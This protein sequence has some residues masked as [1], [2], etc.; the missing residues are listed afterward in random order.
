MRA[1]GLQ[2]RRGLRLLA[3]IVGVSGLALTVAVCIGIADASPAPTQSQTIEI[4]GLPGDAGVGGSYTLTVSGGGSGNPVLLSVESKSASVCELNGTTVTGT[5]IGECFIDATQA[6]GNGYAAAPDV[7][8]QFL[9]LFAG[10]SVSQS[11]ASSSFTLGATETDTV[12]VTGNAIAGAPQGSMNFYECGPGIATCDND[13]SDAKF[14]GSG[15]VSTASDD[16]STVVSSPVTP[17]QAGTYCFYALFNGEGDYTTNGDESSDACFTVNAPGSADTSE[18]ASFTSTGCFNWTVPDGV[19]SVQADAIGAAGATGTGAYVAA[20]GDGDAVSGAL[21]VSGGQVL[22]VCVDQGGAAGGGGYGGAGGG[23]AGVAIGASFTTQTAIVAGGGGGGAG[24]TYYQG[25]P[26]QGDPAGTGG[27]NATTADG[28]GSGTT[29]EAND[30]GGS[31]GGGGGGGYVGG[32]GGNASGSAPPTAEGGG[33]GTDYCD[34]TLVSNC[35]TAAKEGTGSSSVTLT[36]SL[37]QTISFNS[38]PPSQAYIGDSYNV[39]VSGGD[40]GNAVVLS[41]DPDSAPDACTVSSDEVSFTGLGLCQIDAKQAGGDGYAAAAEQDQQVSV[42]QAPSQISQSPASSSFALGA[43]DTDYV[44]VVGNPQTGAPTGN[45]D[46]WVCG[47]AASSCSPGASDLIT[48][49][50]ASLASE[51]ADSSLAIVPAFT[52]GS[53][54]TYCYAVAYSSTAYEYEQDTSADGCFAVNAPASTDTSE[55]ASFTSGGCYDWTVPDGVSSVQIDAIGAA[56]GLYGGSGDGVSGTAALS[57]G[58]AIDVCVDYGGGAPGN[59]GAKNSG[60]GASGVSAAS[61][62][63]D[64][65]IIAGGG[66]GGGQYSGAEGGNAGESAGGG[67]AAGEGQGGGG[68]SNSPIAGGGSGGSGT[69]GNGASG[70]AT[71]ASGPG[72]GGAGGAGGSEPD[73]DGGGGGGGAGYYGGGGGGGSVNDGDGGGAGG[74]GSDY[75]DTS[76]SGCAYASGAGIG[77]VAGSASGD[78]QVRLTYSLD[79]SFSFDGSPPTGATAG[80]SETISATP[81]ASGEPVTFQVSGQCSSS[82]TASSSVTLENTGKGSCEVDANEAG[83]NG[84]GAA[85][86][87]SES[88]DIAPA[89]A[90]VSQTPASSSFTLG[91]PENDNVTLTGDASLGAP[92]GQVDVWV[93]GPSLIAAGCDPGDLDAQEVSS[94]ALSGA[95]GDSSRAVALSFTPSATGTYCFYASYTS[96]DSYASSADDTTDGCFTVTAVAADATSETETFTA[97]GQCVNWNVPSDVS[98]L[99]ADAVGAAGLGGYAGYGDGVSGSFVASAKTALDVC[100]DYG[101]GGGGSR[102]TSGGGASGVARGGDFSA[103]VIVAGGGGSGG[104]AGGQG[105]SAGLPSGSDGAAGSPTG[106]GGGGGDNTLASGGAPGVGT[107]DG[108]SGSATNSDGPGVGGDGGGTSAWAGGGGGGGYYGGG[109]GAGSTIV[110]TGGGGGGGGSDYCAATCSVDSGAGTYPGAGAA[111]GHANVTLT[112]SLD[113]TIDFVGAPNAADVGDT[114]DAS[115]NVTSGGPVS[116]SIDSSTSGNC[117]IN[118]TTVTFTNTGTCQIDASQAGGDGYGPVST[119][120]IVDVQ[121][122]NLTGTVSA[123][124]SSF[125]LGASDTVTLTATGNAVAGAPG[126]S[127]TWYECGPSTGACDSGLNQVGSGTLSAVSSDSSQALSP[128]LTPTTA[129]TYCVGVTWSEG[130]NYQVGGITSDLACFTVNAPATGDTTES[131]QFTSAGCGDWTV[132]DGVTSV[133]ADAVGAAGAIGTIA[134]AAGGDGDGVSAT[135]AVSPGETLDVCVDQGGGTSDL[136]GSGGGAS[137][138]SLTTGFQSPALVAGGGGGGGGGEGAPGGNAGVAG[139]SAASGGGAG[140]ALGAGT[141]STDAGPGSGAPGAGTGGG[142]GGGGYVGGGGG[143]TSGLG[144]GGGA[145]GTDH[146][147][148]GGS[149][150]GCSTSEAAGTQTVAGSSSGDAQVTLTYSLDQAITFNSNASTPYVG[151]SYDVNATSDGGSGQPVELSIDASASTSGACSISG[152]EVQFTGIGTCQI[153]ANQAGGNGYGAAPQTDQVVQI[154]KAVSSTSSWPTSST[155]TLGAGETDNVSVTGQPS[156]G[157][158]SGSISFY[159]CGSSVT[160]CSSQADPVGSTKLTAAP[161]SDSSTAISPAFTPTGAGT[162]CFYAVYAGD[163]TNLGSSDSSSDECFTVDAAASGD[164]TEHAQFTTSGCSDWT[165][166]NDVSSVQADA[167]GAAGGGNGG[168]GDGVSATLSVSGG[169]TLDVCVDQGGASGGQGAS[170]GGGASGVASS[171]N[172]STPVLV[173]GGGGGGAADAAGLAAGSGA[174]G[175]SPSNSAGPGAGDPGRNGV[176]GGGGGGGGGYVGGYGGGG[177]GGGG[178]GGTDYCDTALA[179]S[180]STSAGAGTQTVAGSSS[181]DAQVTLTYSLDQVITFNSTASEPY[182]GESYDVNATSDGGSGQPVELSI[183]ATASTPDACTISGEEVQFTGLGTCQIDA[184]Q[185]GGKGYGAAPL[186]DQ[187]INVTDPPTSASSWPA[188]SAIALGGSDTDHLT[189]TGDAGLSAPAGSVS[190]YVC[191]PAASGCSSTADP[192][193]TAVALSAGTGVS[194]TAVSPA[195]TPTSSGTYCFYAVY[196]GA[197]NYRGSNDSTSDECF[198]VNA[199]TGATNTVAFTSAGCSDWTVPADVTSVSADAVGA[200]GQNGGGAGSTGGNGDEVAATLSVTPGSTLDVCVDQGAGAGG[201]GA[202]SGGGGGGASGVSLAADFSAPALVAGGGGGG[203]GNGDGRGGSGGAA[204]AAGGSGE[205]GGQAGA[206]GTSANYTPAGPGV[207]GAGGGGTSVGGGGGGGGGYSAGG[208]G[209]DS[210]QGTGGGGAGGTDYCVDSASVSACSSNAGAGTQAVAGS[211]PGDARV[212]LTYSMGQLLAFT[213]VAP[214]GATVGGSYLVSA[215]GGP[216]GSPVV[217]SIDASSTSGA[218]VVSGA[219]V[220]F[221]GA[222]NCVVDANQAGGAGYSAAPQANQSFTI[223]A[224]PATSSGTPP[225]TPSPTPQP[226]AV[227]HDATAFV[228]VSITRHHGKLVVV[229]RVP[230]PGELAVLATHAKGTIT[231]A[232]LAPGASRSAFAYT[233]ENVTAAGTVSVTLPPSSF[234]EKLLADTLLPHHGRPSLSIAVLFR[235]PDGGTSFQR[236]SFTW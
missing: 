123:V 190:F 9:V 73:I 74:G 125:T 48:S 17:S 137:G 112:Y 170:G 155:F 213:S 142:G 99:Q 198:V 139:D 106:G 20:G 224:A 29:G 23:A 221:T 33:G 22:D 214:A 211:A 46:Y 121:D 87:Q 160:S 82:S 184:N 212:T 58:Q 103:P 146:C 235:A 130:G 30:S 197:G 177:P 88:F 199:P 31:F 154:S 40:S 102:Y 176:S 143:S 163:G 226:S 12:T 175:G 53:A 133:Q 84:Y 70:Q 26:G 32:A 79:Q 118:G 196:A 218:C 152:D 149:V 209:G 63:T 25:S 169:E 195:F 129:G 148:D 164:T 91:G 168:K 228:I 236:Q 15:S 104:Q 128:A 187:S 105:G 51:S 14:L 215:V 35:S 85:A 134:D 223:V 2:G 222:G 6:G 122:A 60:G 225:S 208:G 90:Q 39:S 181:G 231:H 114:Y 18:S 96:V 145:G 166:P 47:P 89:P 54:G 165:V 207:G 59:S 66:G 117:T 68:G 220:T 77:T 113:Q 138:V 193:G 182:V 16:S 42:E 108:T 217:F 5:G 120:T 135:L 7:T 151:D 95:S 234:G 126:N 179:T 162:Y 38:N 101:G 153:D 4:G 132:P 167:V 83:G 72:A 1:G 92:A 189:V 157:A 43:A 52:P 183:D 76:V 27:G 233:T 37:A 205:F 178:N 232:L 80:G 28:P 216:S 98:S 219:T 97:G 204:G 230:G 150:S 180:C 201:S 203:G 94:G 64:P 65:L 109:G 69:A 174:G 86:E 147:V 78:A 141:D 156:T 55:S 173:A 24:I 11:V 202:P 57:G 41:V 171:E 172:F 3:C 136:G 75:C 194:S 62:F 119:H 44:T 19:S 127:V 140:G 36:Y 191:G 61:G 71:D 110:D 21:D 111:A 100:V 185:A 188:S 229:I 56:G 144:G 45:V 116:F 124:S 227:A 49:D 186:A 158:P 67:G 10:S 8:V 161:N 34:A 131:A 200:A 50:N 107:S 81:G 159:V 192:V 93:C 206:V 210:N 115:A 13:I